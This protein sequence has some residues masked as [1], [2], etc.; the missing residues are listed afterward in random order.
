ME[1]KGI[2]FILI[3]RIGLMIGLMNGQGAK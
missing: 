3:K 2:V 1:P